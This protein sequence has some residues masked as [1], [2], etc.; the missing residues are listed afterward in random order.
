MRAR[1]SAA[2]AALLLLALLPAS[3]S[4]AP[5]TKRCRDDQRARCGS[6]LVPLIR[7]APDG[8]GRKLRIHF[9]V[10]PRTDRSKPALEPIVTVEG[11]PGYPSIDSADSYLFMLGPLRRRHDMIVMDNRGTGRSGAVDC[12]R[13]QNLKGVYE[14]EVGRCARKLGRAVNAC[15]ASGA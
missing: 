6:V 9:R 14:R 2:V 5:A 1:L 8:G 13:L 10:F 12:P 4:A 11:G 15:S 7:A 3:A